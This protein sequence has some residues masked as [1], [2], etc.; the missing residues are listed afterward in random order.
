MALEFF[1]NFYR[2]NLSAAL[3]GKFGTLI[4][5]LHIFFLYVDIL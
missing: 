3:N 4:K 2:N 5:M 1:L